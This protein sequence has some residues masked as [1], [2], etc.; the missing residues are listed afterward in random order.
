LLGIDGEEGTGLITSDSDFDQ[1]EAN[2]GYKITLPQHED[3]SQ[4]GH[5][6]AALS[7]SLKKDVSR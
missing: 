1:A 3:H 7:G 6:L 2:A 5:M 4:K